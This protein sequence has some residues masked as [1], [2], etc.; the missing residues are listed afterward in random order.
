MS[1]PPVALLTT[2]PN[3][4]AMKLVVPP[5]LIP[6]GR[7]NTTVRSTV[8]LYVAAVL[9]SVYEPILLNPATPP[10]VVPLKL[11]RVKVIPVGAVED[12]VPATVIWSA[13]ALGEANAKTATIRMIDSTRVRFTSI[14]PV[15]LHKNPTIDEGYSIWGSTHQEKLSYSFYGTY[16]L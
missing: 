15:G 10:T 14:P 2:V 4:L 3:T 6:V 7:V 9:D 8:V 1:T 16:L 5:P 12:V 13:R 11:P